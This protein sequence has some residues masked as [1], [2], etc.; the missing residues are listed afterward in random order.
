[1]FS[2][3]GS[4]GQSA[5][6]LYGFPDRYPACCQRKYLLSG[7]NNLK[8]NLSILDERYS[9]YSLLHFK[10]KYTMADHHASDKYRWSF[11]SGMMVT[12]S[13][14]GA[15]DEAGRTFALTHIGHRCHLSRQIQN[16]PSSV[17][18]FPLVAGYF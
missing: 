12:F 9:E 5:S 16:D 10:P 2:G 17:Y 3:K 11:A 18:S 13:A 6:E 7:L 15:V 8:I 14:I 4:E 1:M